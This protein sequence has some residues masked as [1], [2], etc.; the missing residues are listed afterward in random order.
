[1][2]S[3]FI[4][5]LS[6]PISFV[7]CETTTFNGH[8]YEFLEMKEDMQ[9]ARTIAKERGG[10]LAT[11]TDQ[12]EFDFI[13]SFLSGSL[14]LNGKDVL[15]GGELV[16]SFWRWTSGPE[17]DANVTISASK[18]DVY[19]CPVYCNWYLYYP[20]N[21]AWNRSPVLSLYIP[22]DG[23]NAGFRDVETTPKYYFLI[24]W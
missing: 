3:F 18:R 20:T 22:P 11:I 16:N 8:I 23:K 19:D 14:G 2:F 1:M 24:E 17:G 9:T 4:L 7:S 10:Y 12:N 15:L 13:V 21:A 6:S 5:L